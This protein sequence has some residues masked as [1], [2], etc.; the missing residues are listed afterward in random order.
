MSKF[1]ILQMITPTCKEVLNPTFWV[2]THHC[3][4]IVYS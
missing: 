2:N 1:V 3:T 4:S